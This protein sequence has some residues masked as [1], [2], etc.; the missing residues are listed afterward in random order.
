MHVGFRE[1][2]IVELRCRH[3]IKEGQLY[4]FDKDANVRTTLRG[5]FVLILRCFRVRDDPDKTV[6]EC[7]VFDSKYESI[8]ELYEFVFIQRGIRI[9]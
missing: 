4:K 1:T 2:P 7:Y 5:K 6:A 3:M 8:E 9:A